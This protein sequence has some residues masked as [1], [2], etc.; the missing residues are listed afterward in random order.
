MKQPQRKESIQASLAQLYGQLDNKRA[1][2]PPPPPRVVMKPR[3]GGLKSGMKKKRL[4]GV[5]FQN[6]ESTQSTTPR[7]KV[8][9]G[10][11]PEV[12]AKRVVFGTEDA[13][14]E[15]ILGKT[16]TEMKRN[17]FEHGEAPRKAVVAK[18]RATSKIAEHWGQLQEEARQGPR[19]PMVEVFDESSKGGAYEMETIELR[20]G[21]IV[22]LEKGSGGAEMDE[23]EYPTALKLTIIV[24]AVSLA[25]F[26][27]GLVMFFLRCMM[28]WL[29]TCGTRM[30]QLSQS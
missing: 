13:P 25:V 28:E 17:I 10:E 23:I 14:A 27:T 2:E 26:C 15:V 9:F 21:S 11:E 6:E 24:F 22:S 30:E 3:K 7:K 20:D 19:K 8:G 12:V 5:K 18:E 16:K 29:L 4:S 1:P